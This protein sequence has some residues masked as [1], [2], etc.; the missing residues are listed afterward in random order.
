[1]AGAMKGLLAFPVKASPKPGKPGGDAGGD[2]LEEK[3]EGETKDPSARFSELAG[4]AYDAAKE[5]DRE[6]FVSSLKA[7][8]RECVE[9]YQE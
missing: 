6:G 9:E 5:D 2:P 3:S 8:I 7:A 4:N 1:M